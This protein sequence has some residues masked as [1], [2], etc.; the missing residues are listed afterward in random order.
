MNGQ[1]EFTDFFRF[2]QKKCSVFRYPKLATGIPKNRNSENSGGNSD[3]PFRFPV[4]ENMHRKSEDAT[5]STSSV[6]NYTNY[7]FAYC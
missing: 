6:E 4:N 1:N 3:F 2:F 5:K 7:G